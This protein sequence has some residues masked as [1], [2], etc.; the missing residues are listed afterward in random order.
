MINDKLNDLI[1]N[2]YLVYKVND[3][4]ISLLN[5]NLSVSLK[6][7]YKLLIE[8]IESDIDNSLNYT[9]ILRDNGIHCLIYKNII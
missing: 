8:S 1:D 7:F 6:P 5:I 9:N 3:Y 2:G 4:F